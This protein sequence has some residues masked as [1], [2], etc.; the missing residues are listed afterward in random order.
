VLRESKKFLVSHIFVI[1]TQ[2]YQT[3]KP[4]NFQ[5]TKKAL[6]EEV[7]RVEVKKSK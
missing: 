4:Q 3:T 2:E 6:Q 5:V 1:L 7:I